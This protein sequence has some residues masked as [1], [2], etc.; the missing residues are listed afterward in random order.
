[1]H[2]RDRDPP[3][4]ED[5]PHIETLPSALLDFY[6]ATCSP[7]RTLEPRLERIV[8]EFPEVPTYRVDIDQDLEAARRFQVRSLP[9][10]LLLRGGAEAARLD[11]LIRDEQ[12]RE[13]FES[14]RARHDEEVTR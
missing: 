9:T 10:L 12:I 2:G 14:A 8:G 6:Q 11:G 3:K 5:L 1:M 4:H 13:L 7:C